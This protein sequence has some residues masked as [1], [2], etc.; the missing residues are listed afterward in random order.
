[1]TKNKRFV[2]GLMA[3]LTVCGVLFVGA[4]FVV[5]LFQNAAESANDGKSVSLQ[6]FAKLTPGEMFTTTRDK[7]GWQG[8]LISDSQTGRSRWQLM[9]WKNP[10]GSFLECTFKDGD[11]LEK[12]QHGLR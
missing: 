12:R 11:L 1:M 9:R 4:G 7:I 6:T 10:D 2:L 8:E 5:F 3:A